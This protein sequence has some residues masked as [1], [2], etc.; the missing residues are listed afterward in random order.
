MKKLNILKKTHQDEGT[1]I[2]PV[3]Q[4]LFFTIIFKGIHLSAH[5]L[6]S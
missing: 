6:N 5:L 3:T 1:V 4:K 2:N